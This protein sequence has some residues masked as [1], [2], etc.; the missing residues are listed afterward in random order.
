MPSNAD[1]IQRTGMIAAATAI[2]ASTPISDS[3]APPVLGAVSAASTSSSWLNGNSTTT[4]WATASP[5]STA[6]ASADQPCRR[7]T[8]SQVR[9]TASA[10][11]ATGTTAAP[12][13][14]RAARASSATPVPATRLAKRCSR[15]WRRSIQPPRARWASAATRMNAPRIGTRSPSSTTKPPQIR[16]AA[17]ATTSSAV[18]GRRSSRRTRI[19]SP[20]AATTLRSQNPPRTI[21]PSTGCRPGQQPGGQLRRGEHE[22]DGR[23]QR[24]GSEQRDRR[25]ADQDRRDERQRQR[26]GRG[27]DERRGDQGGDQPEGRDLARVEPDGGGRG[28][29]GHDQRAEEAELGRDEAVE[30]RRRHEADRR[31]AQPHRRDDVAHQGVPPV[32]EHG[33]QDQRGDRRTQP[34]QH[35]HRLADPAA[36]ERE[37]QEE[38]RRRD[39]REAA[40]P[41]Q[42]PAREPFLE[43]AQRARRAPSRRRPA[44]A[45]ARRVRLSTGPRSPGQ[46]PSAERAATGAGGHDAGCG[47]AAR[48]SERGGGGGPT[49][50][51][52]RARPRARTTAEPPSSRSSRASSARSRSSRPRTRSWSMPRPLRRSGFRTS[53]SGTATTAPI[54]PTDA[55]PRKR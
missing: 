42:R 46:V 13:C 45:W 22:R 25:R 15:P 20:A 19:S 14:T 37:A 41:G 6:A 9:A 39:E 49:D 36:A 38:D 52:R 53:G 12:S 55:Q 34:D 3:V 4:R 24:P 5:P 29:D 30:A 11:Q 27:L 2:A 43:V 32:E 31:D 10:A 23:Q 47:A 16:N 50:G 26:G 28:G 35:P 40:G 48:R 54:Y 8:A 21:S 44:A 7:R 17:L 51:G 33:A 1:R 18:A